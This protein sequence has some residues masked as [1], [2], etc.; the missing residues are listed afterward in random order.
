MT[1]ARAES[2]RV[3]PQ[4]L[5][6]PPAWP[7][8]VQPHLCLRSWRR[9]GQGSCSRSRSAL[10]PLRLRRDGWSNHLD[11]CPAAR[12]AGLNPTA[13][14]PGTA[15]PGRAPRCSPGP[16]TAFRAA[17][18]KGM[19]PDVR[20]PDEDPARNGVCVGFERG[21]RK[22]VIS[23]GV[24]ALCPELLEGLSSSTDPSLPCSAEDSWDKPWQWV[25]TSH[26]DTKTTCWGL[27]RP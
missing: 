20:E 16:G 23:Q 6:V 25:L 3:P 15:A 10:R 17:R 26:Q 7:R 19:E 11:A 4:S 18:D 13:A 21:G 2:E 12:P 9:A 22:G 27:E 1:G 24:P 8:A 5:P 14:G